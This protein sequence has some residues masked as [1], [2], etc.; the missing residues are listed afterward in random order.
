MRPLFS[1]LVLTFFVGFI[2]SCVSK[3]QYD[4]LEE[5]KEY[6]E[7]EAELAD[8]LSNEF[9][10]LANDTKET[11][12][13]LKQTTDELEQLTV[14]NISLNR[15]YQEVLKKYNRLISQNQE[16]LSTSS[17]EKQS[18]EDQ[19]STREEM[20][21]KKERD[22]RDLEFQLAEREQRLYAMEQGYSSLEGQVMLSQQKIAELESMLSIK[23]GAMNQLRDKINQTLLGF[24]DT[25]LT[26]TEQNGKVYISLSQN[27]LFKSGSTKIDWKGKKALKQLAEILNSDEEIDIN[28]EG[29]TD[30][31]GSA[32]KNW[33]LSVQR[34]T[35][36]VKV[37]VGYG[38]NA[39]RITAS[40]R[41]LHFPIASNATSEGKAQ[42]RRTEI[43]LSPKLDELYNL[44]NKQ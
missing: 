39:E 23:E 41:G 19:L 24:S 29:H 28:V 17:Y 31:D 3:K 33:D 15:S 35:S 8:S 11:E 16:V 21:D 6:Y 38:V 4:E 12:A 5:I 9:R 7:A 2:S 18:L 43:I 42:N 25:D 40:G 13:Q 20:L 26:V 36:V 14:T 30:S 22:L 34:A 27:L 37:L 10:Q 32:A 1:I 44:L